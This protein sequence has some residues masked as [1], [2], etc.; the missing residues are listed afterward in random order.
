MSRPLTFCGLSSALS[1]YTRAPGPGSRWMLAFSCRMRMP[2]VLRLCVIVANLPPPVPKNMS[3]SVGVGVV[4]L[5][6]RLEIG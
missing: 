5:C 1:E 2:P 6:V 3:S 4:I